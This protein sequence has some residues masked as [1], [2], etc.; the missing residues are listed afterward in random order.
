MKSS[1]KV[2]GLIFVFIGAFVPILGFT[3]YKVRDKEYQ[4]VL[5]EKEEKQ[6]YYAILEIEKIGF[7][8]ELFKIDSK[9]NNVN[10]NILVHENSIFPGG[11]VSNLI[12][13]AHSGVGSNAYFKDLYKLEKFDEIKLYYQGYLWCYEIEKIEYQDKT[14]VLYLLE[15]DIHMIALSTCTKYDNS[16]QTI[17]Y[18]VLK[19]KEK[20]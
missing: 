14:G 9:E 12:L 10:H 20:L 15:K 1:W 16:K 3:S 4:I 5:Q 18:G 13:A 7:K 11:E 6:D 8:R 17:Y 19:N 2:I